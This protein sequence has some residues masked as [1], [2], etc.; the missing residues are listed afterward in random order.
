MK[1]LLVT[2]LSIAVMIAI[3]LNSIAKTPSITSETIA[4]FDAES[5]NLSDYIGK[6]PV[7][8]KFWASWCVPCREEMA[9][10]ENTYQQHGKNIKVLSVNIFINETDEAIKNVQDKFGISFPIL[11]DTK[12]HLAKAFDFAGTPYHVL[13]NKEG[14]IVHKGHE[15]NDILDRKIA[16]LASNSAQDLL[17]TP[18]STPN[19]QEGLFQVT[20]KGRSIVYFTATWCDWYLEGLRP[21]MSK[22]CVNAQKI[23]DG[24]YAQNR[25]IDFTGLVTALWTGEKDLE[26]FKNKYKVRY[27][28]TI[29]SKDNTFFHYK[30]KTFPTLVIFD[31]GKEVM[32]LSNF[33]SLEKTQQQL[34]QVLKRL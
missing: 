14:N 11:L 3:S 32:R 20:K 8:L 29:D 22:N 34:D 1:N 19:T 9:H 16:L 31:D 28:L 26:K 23:V 13:I 10:L 12:G 6:E 4:T 2:S 17:E 24:I 25:D 27:P 30:I 21:E 33:E 5:V 15:A 7:Y 18:T